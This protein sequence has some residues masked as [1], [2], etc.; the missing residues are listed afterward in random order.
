MYVNDVS[1]TNGSTQY[2][3]DVEQ[4]LTIKCTYDVLLKR[5]PPSLV[6]VVDGVSTPLNAT[7]DYPAFSL[8][9]PV[10][11][12]YRTGVACYQCRTHDNN[13]YTFITVSYQAGECCGCVVYGIIISTQ[14]PPPPSPP[15]S[16]P[17][18]VSMV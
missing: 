17:L 16:P 11:Q 15:P 9:Y 5:T 4:L 10:P 6:R 1:L 3:S 12:E 14:T 18:E 8:T 13:Y 2:L 7:T